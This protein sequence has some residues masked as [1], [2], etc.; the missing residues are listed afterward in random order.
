MASTGGTIRRMCLYGG[1]G[2]RRRRPRP[3]IVLCERAPFPAAACRPA[4][5]SRIRRG[6]GADPGSTS[7]ASRQ[8]RRRR[9]RR[10]CRAGTWCRRP[11]GI[12]RPMTLRNGG[13]ADAVARARA[14]CGAVPT[15]NGTMDLAHPGPMRRRRECRHAGADGH[16]GLSGRSLELPTRSAGVAREIGSSIDCWRPGQRD[17][18]PTTQTWGRGRRRGRSA[19]RPLAGLRHGRTARSGSGPRW[20]RRA[21][22][23]ARALMSSTVPQ[24]GVA[25]ILTDGAMFWPQRQPR[26]RV[27]AGRAT[28]R[29]GTSRHALC[30]CASC[31]P[32]PLSAPAVYRIVGLEAATRSIVSCEPE[33]FLAVSG[34]MSGRVA[35]KPVSV[36][37]GVN[38]CAAPT[39][40]CTPASPMTR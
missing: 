9:Q 34:T 17:G 2:H 22:T 4:P 33:I 29:R 38:G 5:S 26:P 7:G 23:D 28:V 15:T 30:P 19:L 3:G 32:A 12:D 20:R 13:C 40:T 37:V 21:W 24:P 1:A 39:A 8:C 35:G 6:S 31:A 14:S 25:V 27:V 16:R 36:T 10:A 11:S 18:I